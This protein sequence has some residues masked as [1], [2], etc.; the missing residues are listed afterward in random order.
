[1]NNTENAVLVTIDMQRFTVGVA[2]KIGKPFSGDQVLKA[3]HE[4]IQ[5]FVEA[6]KSVAVVHFGGSK[7]FN[8][9]VGK[10][11]A[12]ATKSE[13]VTNA[14]VNLF[15]KNKPSAH[16]N[17]R[18]VKYLREHRVATVYLMGIT[19]DNGI[20]NTARDLVKAGYH[21]VTISDAITSVSLPKYNKALAELQELGD[22]TTTAQLLND[23]R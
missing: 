13:L 8:V 20:L 17:I 1:M 6:Q 23:L 15:E 7:I 21:V 14:K 16:T 4:L 18:F 19:A 9:L 2:N 3:H 10:F 11:F 22:V 12:I 5:A